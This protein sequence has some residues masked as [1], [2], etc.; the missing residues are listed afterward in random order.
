MGVPTRVQAPPPQTI[1]QMCSLDVP[2]GVCPETGCPAWG[3][4][5]LPSVHQHTAPCQSGSPDEGGQEQL[6]PPA[7]G[8][9]QRG[10]DRA[11]ESPASHQLQGGDGLTRL[12]FVRKNKTL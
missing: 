3:Q 7:Q 6:P 9:E 1:L 10:E 8:G 12:F 11:E 5:V 4:T 2:E